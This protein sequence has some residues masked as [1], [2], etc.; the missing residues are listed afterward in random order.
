MRDDGG[1]CGA[2]ARQIGDPEMELKAGAQE[3]LHAQHHGFV[4]GWELNEWSAAEQEWFARSHK[5]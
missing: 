1:K 4:V 5:T 2:E 3:S